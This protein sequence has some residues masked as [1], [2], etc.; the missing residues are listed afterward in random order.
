MRQQIVVRAAARDLT[1]QINRAQ[2]CSQGE[3][4]SVEN[5]ALIPF[6]WKT[7]RC[8]AEVR[9]VRSDCLNDALNVLVSTPIRDIKVL[10]QSRRAMHARGYTA[11]DNKFDLRLRQ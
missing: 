1:K 6:E 10:S 5:G 9:I 7:A 2:G 11:N 3:I 4:Q 8:A